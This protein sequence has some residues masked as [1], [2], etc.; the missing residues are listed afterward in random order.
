M[1][2]FLLLALAQAPN[3]SIYHVDPVIDAGASLAMIAVGVLIDREKTTWEGLSPCSGEGRVPT[4]A[5]LKAFELLADGEGAC[6]RDSIGTFEV[7][8]ADL[9]SQMAGTASDVLLWILTAA[10]YA[11]SVTDVFVSDTQRPGLRWGEEAMVA[12]E[13][14]A[15]ALLG[16]NMLKMIVQR[17]RPLTHNTLYSK[18]VRYGGDARLSFPSGHSALAFTSAS[19]IA[20]AAQARHGNSPTTWI[21]GSVAYLTAAVVAYLRVQ[22]GKHFLTDVV[23]GAIAGVVAGLV[24]P[25]LHVRQNQP[26]A[27]D[28]T[29]RMMLSIGGAF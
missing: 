2:A 3:G 27:A 23:G 1:N 5:E 17:P 29:D 15:A 21:A 4:E 9:G 28:G 26:P 11:F 8:V 6:G 10:P 25:T 20:Y 18:D 7:F 19:L 12:V 14:Q 16:T 24:I 13:A 22:S